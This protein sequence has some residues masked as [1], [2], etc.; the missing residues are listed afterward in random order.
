MTTQEVMLLV[1]HH[2][3]RTVREPIHILQVVP[4]QNKGWGVLIEYEGLVWKQI[5]D[6]KGK[7]GDLKLQ[8]PVQTAA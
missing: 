5:V 2:L 4:E 7:I 3:E 8:W 6:A 1:Q